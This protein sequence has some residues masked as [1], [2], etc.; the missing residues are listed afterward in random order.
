MF[1]RSFIRHSPRRIANV[2]ASLLGLLALVGAGMLREAAADEV[3]DWNIAGFEVSAAGGQNNVVISRTMAMV[4]LAVH[5]ALN[6]IERRYEP[7]LYESRV[8]P[9]A[10]PAAAIAAAARDVLVGV[11]PGWGKPEQR[12]KA[13]GIVDSAYTAALAKVPDGPSKIQG[14]AVGQAAAAAM[15]AARKTDGSSAPPQYTPGAAAGQWRPH[16]NPV[17]A[18]PPIS[19]PA[20]AAGNSPAVLPQWGQVSP[21]TMVAPWQFRLLGPPALVSADYARDYEEVKRLGGKNSS[22]R[23]AEQ[24]EIARFWYEGSPQGWS[25]IARIVAAERGLDRWDNARLLALVNVVI[26]DGFVAG[27]DTRYL[28]NF[29]R[30]VTAIRAGDA[31]GNEATAADA[32]WETFL[33]TPPI[34]D[35]PSTHSVAGGAASVVLARFFGNDQVA[36]TTTSGPPF[37]GITRSFKSFSQAAQENADSRVYAGIHFRSACKDG[38]KLGQQIGRRGFTQYLQAYQM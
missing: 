7:Y 25:R 23:T 34:P 28:Y 8:E 19:D 3:F 4:H 29:W 36:F 16:P 14:I 2:T 6:A 31:D 27:F 24:S 35:Y 33:N 12:E 5:D 37:A 32:A 18:D 17:P 30:P 1:G 20:L 11:L 13:L 10:D 9:A 15:L 22:A 21:F 38:I 26:A